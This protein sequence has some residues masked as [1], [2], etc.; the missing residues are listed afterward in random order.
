MT[1]I[2]IICLGVAALLILLGLIGLINPILP[3]LP[4]IFAAIWL[5]AYVNDYRYI[6]PITLGVFAVLTLLGMS[7]DYLMSALGAKYAGASPRAIWGAI[8]GGLLGFFFIPWGIV[9]G[10]SLGAM[11]G[12]F[13][14]NYT[15]IHTSKVGLQTF[16]GLIIGACIKL[17]IAFL[18]LAYV[19]A[20][21]L[22]YTLLS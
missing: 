2:T 11:I 8:I 6:G 5:I 21:H 15:L 22:Y 13:S 3:G 19:L 1:A 18:M 16:I 17:G 20:V 12:E 4:F 10:P 7:A 9:L 14:A